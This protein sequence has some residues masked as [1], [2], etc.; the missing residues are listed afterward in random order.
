MECLLESINL[1]TS[2]EHLGSPQRIMESLRGVIRSMQSHGCPKK[3]MESQIAHSA[4]QGISGY[5]FLSMEQGN[6]STR[7]NPS[8]L[9]MGE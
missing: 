1:G 2:M 3:L 7:R 9:C 8:R 5:R 6:L 4:S